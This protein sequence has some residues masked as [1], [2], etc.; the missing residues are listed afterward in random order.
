MLPA[1]TVDDAWRLGIGDPTPIGW[2]TVA[3]YFAAAWG[4]ARAGWRE[5]H[6]DGSPRAKHSTFWLA[7]AALMLALGINKQLDLQTLVT[8][9]GRRIIV[10]SGLYAQR[11]V[12][13]K[14]FIVAVALACLGLLTTLLGLCR[15]S[16]GRRWP[17]L[18]GMVFILGFVAIRASSFHHIDAFLAARLGGLK[19]N[20]VLELGGIGLVAIGAFRVGRPESPRQGNLP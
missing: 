19:W 2:A 6:H 14:W 18:V 10:S 8:Q 16:L 9:V 11:R 3:A 5:P 17:A 20:W 12:Y 1:D 15:R 4:C 7:L 13:Q